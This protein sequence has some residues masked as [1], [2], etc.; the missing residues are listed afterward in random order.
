V[1]SFV[2]LKKKS[3]FLHFQGH[4][5]YG[6][7]TLLKEYRRDIRRFMKGERKT[8]PSLPHDYF[9]PAAE[10]LLAEFQ[11]TVMSDAKEEMMAYFPEAAITDSL[12]NT[13]HLFARSVYRNWLQYLALRKAE[14][15]TFPT[16]AA[17]YQQR[18]RKRSVAR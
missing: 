9:N 8:Y 14:V 10:K 5:E 17:A 11:R 3:L 18:E 12:Q 16:I 2:K 15:S 7:Q 1:D 6:C 4:P 13:W